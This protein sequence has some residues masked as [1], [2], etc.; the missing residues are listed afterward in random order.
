MSY[1]SIKKKVCLLLFTPMP[2]L[3][4][5]PSQIRSN[6]SGD[7]DLANAEFEVIEHLSVAHGCCHLAFPSTNAVLPASIAL[8]TAALPPS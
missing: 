7:A 6:Q 5:K 2:F 1:G 8:A 3:R 4:E